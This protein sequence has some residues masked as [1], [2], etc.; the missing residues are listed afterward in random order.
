MARRHAEPPPPPADSFERLI[1]ELERLPGVGRRSAE[2]IAYHLLEASR[3]EALAL[4]LAIRDMKSKLRPCR[5][6]GNLTETETCAL[7][8]DPRRDASVLCV[9]EWPREIR[10]IEKSGEFRGRY[11]VLMGRLS[12]LAGVGPEDLRVA[13][14]LERVRAGGVAEIVLATSPTMEGDATAAFLTQ[15]LHALAPK[16]RITRLARGMPAGSDLSFAQAGTIGEAF[17]GRREMP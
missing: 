15:K 16:L 4:A 3:D 11:H 17:K 8:R 14:L 2:R 1:A 12:P 10:A 5:E 13:P 7:C 6:C 9:V